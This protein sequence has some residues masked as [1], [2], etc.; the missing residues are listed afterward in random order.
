[1]LV[2]WW[3]LLRSSILFSSFLKSFNTLFTEALKKMMLEQCTVCIHWGIVG[4]ELLAFEHTQ[5][6]ISK[7]KLLSFC[8]NAYSM[9][10]RHSQIWLSLKQFLPIA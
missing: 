8:F 4:A 7:E 10:Q 1:M 6:N 3:V 5:I 2:E 9:S